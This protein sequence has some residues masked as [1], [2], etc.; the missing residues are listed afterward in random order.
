MSSLITLIDVKYLPRLE[1]DNL[2]LLYKERPINSKIGYNNYKVLTIVSESYYHYLSDLFED[3]A[4]IYY[5][6][7]EF[8][9]KVEKYYI[10]NPLSEAELAKD[11]VNL[12]E[13]HL[14][15]LV[16]FAP[17][18]KY[19]FKI[20]Q[21][22][23]ENSANDMQNILGELDEKTNRLE[24][25][26]EGFSFN[27][28][29]NVHI[30]GGLIVTF[31]DL[32]LCENICTDILQEELNNGWRIIAC[33]VQPNQRRPDYI[34]GRYNPNKDCCETSTKRK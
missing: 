4:G 10:I 33:C 25:T 11:Y 8:I 2:G 18:C 26:I 20:L 19:P 6:D 1:A 22:V 3:E 32:K 21:S 14:V 12:Q 34:L 30:G 24:K 7:S 9:E 5:K 15:D 17:K 23:K 31:N 16:K 29:C 13:T 28:R 27:E